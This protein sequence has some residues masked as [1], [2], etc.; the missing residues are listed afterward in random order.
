MT[1]PVIRIV[2]TILMYAGVVIFLLP[3]ITGRLT[4]GILFLILGAGSAVICGLLRCYL[5]EGDCG[6]HPHLGRDW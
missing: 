1:K 4:T 3:Y 2:L 5:T 6:K